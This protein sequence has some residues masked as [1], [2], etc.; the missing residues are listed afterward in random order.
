MPDLCCAFREE[1]RGS[2]ATASMGPG[3]LTH[4]PL[5]GC[6]TER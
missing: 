5:T 3:V 6:L 4:V 2:K 1:E